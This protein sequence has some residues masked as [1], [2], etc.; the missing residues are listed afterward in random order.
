VPPAAVSERPGVRAVGERAAVFLAGRYNKLV[1]TL[2]QTPWMLDGQRRS[3]TSV[4]ELITDE[5]GK[6][7]RPDGAAPWRTRRSDASAHA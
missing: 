3:P 2:S 6:L 4:Q 5:V 1:R 7:F